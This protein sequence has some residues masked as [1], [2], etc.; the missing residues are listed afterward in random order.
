MYISFQITDYTAQLFNKKDETTVVGANPY[1]TYPPYFFAAISCFGTVGNDK[2]IL[3]LRF[4][5]P[6]AELPQNISIQTTDKYATIWVPEE[7]FPFYLDLLR[8]EKP[9]YGFI[10]FDNPRENRIQ[11]QKEPAGE[12]E[13]KKRGLS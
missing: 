1:G 4:G 7:Q 8:N 3:S 2:W 9:V 10:D 5:S 6:L 11:T 13:K 12:G